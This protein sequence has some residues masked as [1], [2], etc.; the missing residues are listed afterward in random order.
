MKAIRIHQFGGSEQMR[1]EEVEMPK[2]ESGQALVRIRAAGI[3]PVDWMIRER[4]FNPEGTDKV[5]LT[6]GQ[7]F[8]GVVEKI[9]P[10]TQSEFSEG[11]E[12]LGEVFGAF[13]EY[14]V[15]P[16]QDL[17]RKP[18]NIS[19][20]VAAAI[21]MPALT[22]WQMVIDTAQARPGMKFLIHGAGGAVGSFAAQFA[23]LKGAQVIATASEASFAFLREI[24]VDQVIDYNRERFEDN[25][26]D[27]DVVIDPKGGEVQAR[28]WRVLKKGGLLI[29]LIGEI[30]EDAA[31]KAGVRGLAFAMS[32]DAGELRQ[33][34]ELV[35]QGKVKPHVSQVLPLAEARKAMDLNQQG[36]SHGK[37]V[38][39]LA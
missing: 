37:V 7:D 29:N 1:L 8:S 17:V 3:N 36:K 24:G 18:G 20:E 9:G 34:V 5:P 14:A 31:K 21:P 11:D 22:A 4:M 33:I 12:V 25:V 19:F 38:L 6:L 13:A 10:D 26:Q 15:V 2:L 32:Y 16:I 30:D 28:S 27:V 35:E 23:K 39:K